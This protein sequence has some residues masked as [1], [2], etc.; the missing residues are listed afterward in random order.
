[1]TTTSNKIIKADQSRMDYRCRDVGSE[2]GTPTVFVKLSSSD[3]FDSKISSVVPILEQ[4]GWKEKLESGFARLMIEG[5]EPVDDMHREGIEGLLDAV[6]VRFADV[7]VSDLQSVPGRVLQ[8]AVD[9][10]VVHVPKDFDFDRDV[11]E[12]YA[13]Q[14][15][16]FGNVDFVFDMKGK[17]DESY[18]SEIEYEYKIYDSDIYV[19]PVGRKFNTVGKRFGYCE[20]ACKSNTWNLV[21]RNDLLRNYEPEEKDD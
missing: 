6:S 10:Y 2:Q 3:N 17:Q 9:S 16:K 18:I 14:S 1:M 19:R 4:Y 5:T 21:P 8:N 15:R 20:K 12:W 13:D 11:M 7:R